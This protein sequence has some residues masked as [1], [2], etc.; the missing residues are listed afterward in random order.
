MTNF[1]IWSRSRL[2][3]PFLP[4]AGANLVGAGASVWSGT[5]DF[6]SRSRPKKWRLRNTGFH[7]PPPTLC[8]TVNICDRTYVRAQ[9]GAGCVLHPESVLGPPPRQLRGIQDHGQ[10]RSAQHHRHQGNYRYVLNCFLLVDTWHDTFPTD[11]HET[12][13]LAVDPEL[14]PNLDPDPSLFT[15]LHYQL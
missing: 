10:Q 3:P 1:S 5:S 7:P 6:R 15:Q 4:G 2:E 13:R 9:H 8:I 14:C 11:R 12:V